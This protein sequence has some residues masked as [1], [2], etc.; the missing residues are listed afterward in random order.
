MQAARDLADAVRTGLAERADPMKAPEMRAYMK[1][2]MDFLGVQKP[3]R[4]ELTR[5]IFRAHPLPYR[6]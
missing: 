3:A 1:S 5:E 2:E 4:R 6:E